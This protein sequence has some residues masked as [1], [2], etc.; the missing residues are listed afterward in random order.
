MPINRPSVLRATATMVLALTML[1]GVA[2]ADE[3]GEVM[4]LHR[5]GQTSIALQRAEQF[6]AAKPDDTEMRF[7]QG[8]MLADSQ[9]LAEAMAVFVELTIDH[10]EM[11]E[12]HNNLAALYAAKGDYEQA[13]QA[14][15]QAIRAN[16]DYA[17]AH[18]NLGDVYV[19]LAS[20]AYSRA[21]RLNRGSTSVAPKLAL[22]R[23]LLKLTRGDGTNRSKGNQ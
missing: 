8:V 6:L 21:A 1:S 18:E 3:V 9:R 14:L 20:Q 22:A 13:R 23:E 10:P 2:K 7:L 12:P 15:T 5:A 11:A 17:T 16:P 4:R 19:V